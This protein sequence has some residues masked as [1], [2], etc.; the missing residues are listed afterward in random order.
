MIDEQ[1]IPTSMRLPRRILARADA[2]AP[3]LNGHPAFASRAASWVSRSAVLRAALERGLD[4]L[5]EDTAKGPP[6]REDVRAALG[7]IT[8]WIEAAP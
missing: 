7:V 8:R 4:A 5:E 3:L 2:L 1:E 6:E